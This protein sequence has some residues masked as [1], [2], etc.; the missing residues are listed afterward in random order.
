MVILVDMEELLQDIF[1]E[2]TGPK[3]LNLKKT[4]QD[5]LGK[6]QLCFKNISSYIFFT[7]LYIY[8]ICT[9]NDHY[10]IRR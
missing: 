9:A 2:A 8:K 1:R 4:C 10:T 5:A 6:Y 3:L 7:N